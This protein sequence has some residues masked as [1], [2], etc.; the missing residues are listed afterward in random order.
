MLRLYELGEVEIRRGL[1]RTY[2]TIANRDCFSDVED[3][4]K[5]TGAGGGIG[6]G[7]AT[8]PQQ[9]PGSSGSSGDNNG[10][11]DGGVGFSGENE[12]DNEQEGG[13]IGSSVKSAK[14]LKTPVSSI[15]LFI[16]IKLLTFHRKLHLYNTLS[17]HT[18]VHTTV[19]D[20]ILSD[21]ADEQYVFVKQFEK[22][23]SPKSEQLMESL[24]MLKM[25][26]LNDFAKLCSRKEGAEKLQNIIIKVNYYLCWN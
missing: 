24:A 10:K 1:D 3:E 2:A 11:D 9:Q 18:N 15:D 5:S 26:G 8:P 6:V 13:C 22:S 16:A 25:F 19:G 21:L 23:R 4:V 20:A 17:I 12:N 7:T 14:A